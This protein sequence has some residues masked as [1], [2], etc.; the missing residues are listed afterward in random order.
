MSID[1]RF[2]VNL[3]GRQYPTW[4]GVLDLATRSG[5]KSLLTDLVQA[6]SDENNHV[7]IV[8]AT[9]CF[10]DGRSFS[11]YGDASP[12]NVARH[13]QEALIRM[14][15]TRAKGRVLRDAMNVGETLLEELPEEGSPDSPE[16]PARSVPVT[17]A[18]ARPAGTAAPRAQAGGNGDKPLACDEC[19]AVLTMG[20]AQLSER[21]CNGRRLC[22]AHQKAAA[23]G[24]TPH[25]CEAKR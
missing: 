7:A 5:L 21:N 17:Q 25:T 22:L 24:T 8:Q 1:P 11:D 15:S 14:A 23:K 13:I 16:A 20:Q 12:R 9:A 6:P 2:V 18:P 4:P 19:G 3:K 10:E